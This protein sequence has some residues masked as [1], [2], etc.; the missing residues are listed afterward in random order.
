MID[1]KDIRN[2][3]DRRL[4]GLSED[5]AR[6]MRIRVA[7]N[8]ERQANA[9]LKR[10]VSPMLAFV[11][12]VILLTASIAIAEHLNLFGFFGEKDRR[13]ANVAE[14]ANLTAAESVEANDDNRGKAVAVMNS[15][16]FDGQTLNLAFQIEQGVRYEAYTPDASELASMTAMEAMPVVIEHPSA[17][18]SDILMAYNQALT[19]GTP[20]GYRAYTVYPSDHTLTDDGV[21]IPPYAA[22]SAYTEDGVYAEMREFETPLPAELAGRSELH[23]SI[24]LYMATS[25]V[26]FDGKQAYQHTERTEAGEMTGTVPLIQGTVR[27]MYGEGEINGVRCMASARVSPM[28][29]EIAFSSE[30]P[31]TTFLASPPEGV[32]PYDTWVEFTAYD[33]AGRRYRAQGA[34]M[35]EE[36][37]AEITIALMGVGELPETLTLYVFSTWEGRDASTVDPNTMT[38]IDMIVKKE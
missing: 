22:D 3:V 2:K 12:A 34:C 6:R 13:Y 4:S 11:L 14:Q 27:E 8:T 25:T 19:D 28:V 30:A 10:R 26:Y 1:K 5:E 33:E 24:K 23:L 32:D 20:F 17:P 29:A 18:G 31:F 9:A 35:P 36:G 37:C 15:A 16:F 7:I 38:G 21:D